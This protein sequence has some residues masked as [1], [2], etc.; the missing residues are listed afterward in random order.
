MANIIFDNDGKPTKEPA[1]LL[2]R[3]YWLGEH[4]PIDEKSR[5]QVISDNTNLAICA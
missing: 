1:T 2:S 3:R 4:R 5:F